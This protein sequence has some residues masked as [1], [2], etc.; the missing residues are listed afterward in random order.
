MSQEEKDLILK[1]KKNKFYLSN[2][3]FYSEIYEYLSEVKQ[4]EKENE[5]L[6]LDCK[7]EIKPI[8]ECLWL[9]FYLLAVK[10]SKVPQFSSYSFKEDYIH[11]AILKCALV[12]KKFDHENNS[13][14]FAYFTEVIK[15]EYWKIIK[16][17]KNESEKKDMMLKEYEEDLKLLENGD[18]RY[19]NK[20]GF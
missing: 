15:N 19:I 13:N 3:E 7:K 8:P 6:P 14:P 16:I 17:E 10:L 18:E 5:N 1:P 4:I 12:I 20:F 9:K 11:D 2:K